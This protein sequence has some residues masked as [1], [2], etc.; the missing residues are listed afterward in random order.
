M[1]TIILLSLLCLTR[2]LALGQDINP[3]HSRFV[4]PNGLRVIVREDHREP[5]VS[6]TIWY[7]VGS[8]NESAGRSGFAHLFEHLMFEGSEHHRRNFVSALEEVGASNINAVTSHDRTAFYETVPKSALDY[9]LWLESDR[10]RYLPGGIDQTALDTQREVIQN[11][12]R[13]SEDASY[14][15]SRRLIATQAYPIDHP[16]SRPVIGNATDLQAASLADVRQWFEIYYK[17][18]N[19]VIALAGDIDEETARRKIE[20]YFGGIPP[21]PPAPRPTPWI[22]KMSGMRHQSVR[23][24]VPRP[25]LYFVWNI[26]GAGTVDA[27]YLNLVSDCLSRG[28]NSRLFRALVAKNRAEDA[29]ASVSLNEIGGQFRIEVTFRSEQDASDIKREVNEQ[30]TALFIHGPDPEEL[31]RVKTLYLADIVRRMDRSTGVGGESDRLA[32]AEMFAGNSEA[33]AESLKRARTATPEHLKSAAKRWLSDGAYVL[34][35]L[36]SKG[37]TTSEVANRPEAPALDVAPAPRFPKLQRTILSNGLRVV[38]GER[39]EVPIVNLWMVFN[40]GSANDE[41]SLSGVANMTAALLDRG[42]EA[43]SGLQISDEFSNLGAEYSAKSN[44]N[45][46]LI[47]LSSVKW[48]LARSLTTF[49]DVLMHPTFPAT[50]FMIEQ[51]KQLASIQH[52]KGAPMPMAMRLLGEVM[53]QPGFGCGNRFS[54]SGSSESL[55]RMTREDV[56][57]FHRTWFRPNNATLIVVGNVSLPE[58]TAMLEKELARWKPGQVPEVRGVSPRVPA[59]PKIYLVDKP[60]A[61]QSFILAASIGVSRSDPKGIAMDLLNDALGGNLSSRLN[62]NLREKKHWTYGAHSV[63]W[64][65]RD[66]RPFIAYA[67]VQRDKT[68]DA[69]QEFSN[70]FRAVRSDRPIAAEELAAIKSHR[71]MRL[72]GSLQSLDSLTRS[73]ADLIETGLP[74][75]YYLSLPGKI[76]ALTAVDLQNAAE[77]LLRPDRMWWLVVGDRATIKSSLLEAGIGDVEVIDGVK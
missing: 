37:T 6:I 7:H 47:R 12:R 77:I 68:K 26:P 33:Y 76:S 31:E 71:I 52:E 32:Q 1:R 49:A 74:D 55:R 20:N 61:Q 66:Q 58:L 13:Q 3:H 38:L 17:P 28:R 23:D 34:A 14:A 56:A 70:E 10:M 75:D 5:V 16:Y 35:V 64:T 46:T 45:T 39:H 25:R 4:L 44:Y 42:T 62:M 65:A 53:N 30:M 67:A 36:P 11:E 59:K 48:N 69:I 43:R 54:V 50:E 40:T 63:L 24:R 21:G 9:A 29:R 72:P 41:C 22:A 73:I 8:K 27:D 19:A 15:T 18:S 2:V 60:G 57:K 51:G